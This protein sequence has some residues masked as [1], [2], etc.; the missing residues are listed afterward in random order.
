MPDKKLIDFEKLKE[1][2]YLCSKCDKLVC[3]KFGCPI[4]NS[5]PDAVD[6]PIACSDRL[7][8]LSDR[9]V[10]VYFSDTDSWETVHVEDSFANITAGF[11]FTQNGTYHTALG[12]NPES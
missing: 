5:L 6:K 11:S 10:L 4:W 8:E 3:E 2:R 12:N 1:I 7:P 9:S